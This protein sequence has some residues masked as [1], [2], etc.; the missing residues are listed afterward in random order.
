MA[1][2]QTGACVGPLAVTVAVG[3]VIGQAIVIA[4]QRRERR[5]EGGGRTEAHSATGPVLVWVCVCVCLS[6]YMI[7]LY[8]NI[9]DALKIITKVLAKRTHMGHEFILRNTVIAS[10]NASG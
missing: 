6:I 9:E 4:T 1:P 7:T 2:A 5:E 3:V 10:A 8:Y